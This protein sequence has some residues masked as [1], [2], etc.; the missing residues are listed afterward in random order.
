MLVEWVS[1]CSLQLI[2]LKLVNQFCYY[3]MW[4]QTVGNVF[5]SRKV[6]WPRGSQE[7]AS[8][9]SKAKNYFCSRDVKK[10]KKKKKKK[11]HEEPIVR[12]N[13]FHLWYSSFNV[14]LLNPVFKWIEVTVS[15]VRGSPFCLRYSTGCHFLL[16]HLLWF[17]FDI[18]F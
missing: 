9:T 7:N 11:Q 15:P 3:Y 6:L 10:M 14:W 12:N 13:K 16:K 4:L 2:A 17:V 5:Q 18:F 8:K 1:L